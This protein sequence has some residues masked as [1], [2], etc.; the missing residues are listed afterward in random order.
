MYIHLLCCTNCSLNLA[1]FHISV[2]IS[3]TE[4]D[5]DLFY[6]CYF[7]LQEKRALI[8]RLKPVLDEM[9]VCV[10]MEKSAIELSTKICPRKLRNGAYEY[11]RCLDD[12]EGGIGMTVS[13]SHSS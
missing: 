11:V 4:T 13:S 2:S 8:V 3:F 10:E 5:D 12:D 9:A 1:S 6:Y 7:I